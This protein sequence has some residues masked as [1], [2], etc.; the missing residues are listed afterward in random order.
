MAVFTFM[1]LLV[2]PVSLTF[3]FELHADWHKINDKLNMVFL[4]DIVMWFLTGYYDYRTKVIVLDPRI[5]ALYVN[6][7]FRMRGSSI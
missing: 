2:T 6:R 4:C 5:V 7:P 3:Y 1:A